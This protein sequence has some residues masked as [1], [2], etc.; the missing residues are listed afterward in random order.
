MK[1]YRYGY[2]ILLGYALSSAA[3]RIDNPECYADSVYWQALLALLI[4]VGVLY[5]V[6]RGLQEIKDS[7]TT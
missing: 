6:Y 7:D 2:F 4:V 3:T 5:T 1:K